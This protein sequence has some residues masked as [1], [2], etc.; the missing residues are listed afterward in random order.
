[1]LSEKYDLIVVGT[2]FASGFFLKKY[3]E[4]SRP[5]AKILVLERGK[6]RNHLDRLNKAKSDLNFSGINWKDSQ[7]AFINQ[8]PEKVWVFDPNFGGS[9]NCWTGCTPRFLPNDFQLK[10][11]YGVGTDWPINYEAL[12]AY[13]T[14]AERIMSISGPNK[15]PFPKSQKYPLPPHA[16]STVDTLLK[17]K[18]GNLYIS[19]PTARAS[20]NTSNR[21]V[22]CSSSV[23]SLCPVDAKFTIQN[24][25]VNIFEDHRVTIRYETQVVALNTKNN[26]VSSVLFNSNGR[27]AEAE[28]EI[29]ALGANALFNAHIL[30]NSGDS[31]P[32]TG[33]GL[34][35]QVG[36]YAMV[37][38]DGLENLGGSSIIPAN[39]YMLYD[40]E[41]RKKHGAILI[42]SHNTPYIR[43]KIGRWRQLIRL[44]FIAEDLP[45][46]ENKVTISDDPNK[47]RVIF[48]G[49]S[50]YALDAFNDLDR[51]IA[52]IFQGLPIESI[53]I[54][55]YT[56][57]SEYHICS[58]HRMSNDPDNGV[59]DKRLI[60]HQY[61]NLLLLGSGV[62]PTISP[63]NP[64][65]TLSALS[66][67]AADNLV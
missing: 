39:G 64:T 16:L 25:M 3:L 7:S 55:G 38:F 1:M 42:E 50:R 44:K 28:G 43:S 19:Q 31:L 41:H 46:D 59:V 6:V 12:E 2:G 10:S 24:G 33:K 32:L 4:K 29:I 52:K 14:E 54:D 40:G 51:K 36:M 15:T 61:R 60:H 18:F 56:Q 47:P 17:K 66:L 53:Y 48:K 22:C 45:C 58:T 67:M 8:N 37:Y 9:S 35:E 11:K 13:Y 62:F 30:L 63:S 21:G 27:L 5:D 65:L 26:I 57:D 20:K 23:C 49:H 34:S